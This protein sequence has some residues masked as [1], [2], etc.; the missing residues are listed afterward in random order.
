MDT[1]LNLG[2]NDQTVEGLEGARP[3][4]AASPTTATAASSR[5][6]AT[7]CSRSRRTSSSTSSRRVKHERGAQTDTDLDEDGLREVVT[8][9]K[10]VVKAK[11]ASASS[12]RIRSSSCAASRDAVFRSWKN[13][14]AIDVPPHLRDSRPHRHRG[15][16]A[17]DGV[18][19]HR[20][21]LGDRRRLHAQ[22]GDRREGVLRRVP[23]QR[24]GRGRG[25]RRP[26]AAADHRAREGDA[27]AP[28]RSCARSRRASS[29]TT[30][31]SRTSSSRSRTR[32]L[33]MLQTRNGKRTGYAAVVI[34]TD[35]AAE[36]LITPQGGAA[37]GRARSR[38]RSCS[39]RCSTREWK[40][41]PVATK[42]L[43]ASPGAASGQVVFTA[44]HAV[45]WTRAG[46]EGAARPQG[47]GAGR[48]P[49]HGGR[50]RAS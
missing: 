38:S 40:K 44:D 32:R 50:R 48:H 33:Y 46:Q 16:R 42:G 47:D 1:I 4:T 34:A 13:P 7:S 43:P 19:Q 29:G 2:L 49:R 22:P 41:L 30:R 35:L 12:R 17:D 18:R 14:R 27:A 36:K 23:R 31:T 10:E 28:T 24:A 37:A 20:R 39:R 3:A 26:H 11:T 45:E 15:Q 25:G 21:P 6:S 9:Y 8:R 5:C